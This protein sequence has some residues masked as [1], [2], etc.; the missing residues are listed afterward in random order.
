MVG[1][2]AD[3]LSVGSC[4][5]EPIFPFNNLTS[6][7]N[8]VISEF[9]AEHPFHHLPRTSPAYALLFGEGEELLGCGIF[10][11]Q[12]ESQGLISRSS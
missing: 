12:H 2:I 10:P 8:T 1:V 9:P 11:C 7:L 3:P 4:Y 5:L 6:I